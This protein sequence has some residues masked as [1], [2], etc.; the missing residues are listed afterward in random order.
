MHAEGLGD[1]GAEA[2]CLNQCTNKRADVVNTGAI[3]KIAQS[4][5]TGLAGAHLEV[6][7]MKFV[8]EIGM[9]VV[10]ILTYAHQSLVE[11]QTCFNADDGEIEGIRQA[12][13]NALLAVP[14]H[15]FED[16]PRKKKSQTWDACE[17]KWIVES[18]DQR[19]SSEPRGSHQKTRAEIIVNVT[20]VAVTGLN[21]PCAGSGY[22]GGREWN[23]LSRRS[24][25][26][27]PHRR[28]G[29]LW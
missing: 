15:A 20:G 10:Q 11:R 2:V 22:I 19:Y 3:D 23:R 12:N 24:I 8:A 6:D 21:Q 16:K 25:G 26:P 27:G 13:A 7:Q 28:C 9:G 1:A 17:K 29:S 4:F 5:S 18:G 14:N